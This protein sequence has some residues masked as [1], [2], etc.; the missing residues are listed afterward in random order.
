[1]NTFSTTS[2][3]D[4]M[5]DQLKKIQ[6]EISG[7]NAMLDK[8]L[9]EK[10]EE[11]LENFQQTF[12]EKLKVMQTRGIPEENHWTPNTLSHIMKKPLNQDYLTTHNPLRVHNNR[13]MDNN[14][15]H[16]SP[17]VDLNKF[18]WF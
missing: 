15:W 6:D 7:F 10:L 2:R 5:D 18:L 9:D 3:L 17:K 12:L 16:H 1:M 11:K 13:S 8:R 14:I 4:C